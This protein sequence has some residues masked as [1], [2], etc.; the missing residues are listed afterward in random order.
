MIQRGGLALRPA[1]GADA[2]SSCEDIGAFI[3]QIQPA[4]PLTR[5]VEIMCES[6]RG[7]DR[8][9][10]RENLNIYD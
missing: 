4:L 5:A 9:T 1:P 8:D 6:E 3:N 2:C 7:T 10:H